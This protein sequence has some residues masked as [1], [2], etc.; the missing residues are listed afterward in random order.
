MGWDA[1]ATLNGDFLRP[2]GSGGIEDVRL[3]TVFEQ[4]ES[5]SS[6]TS[7]ARARPP[8]NV[9]CQKPRSYLHQSLA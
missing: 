9:P 2:T 6:S 7:M 4:A 8:A 3:R 5:E 1:D